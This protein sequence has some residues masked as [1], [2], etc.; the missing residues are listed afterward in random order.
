MMAV[1]TSYNYKEKEME[2]IH[3]DDI[4]VWWSSSARANLAVT[5]NE[6]KQLNKITLSFRV[7]LQKI[8]FVTWTFPQWSLQ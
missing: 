3:K 4:H 6:L 5:V 2:M 8:T 1:P 7:E